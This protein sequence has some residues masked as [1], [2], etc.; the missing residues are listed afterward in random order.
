MASLGGQLSAGLEGLNEMLDAAEV[1]SMQP[2]SANPEDFFVGEIDAT[3]A[4]RPH[5]G[6]SQ[7]SN[8]LLLH[9]HHHHDHL[10]DDQ[11]LA[12]EADA[13]ELLLG[14][15]APATLHGSDS[16][17]SFPAIPEHAELLMLVSHQQQQQQQQQQAGYS[18]SAALQHQ[19]HQQ[20]HQQQPPPTTF[21]P[22]TNITPMGMGMQEYNNNN[23]PLLFTTT[24]LGSPI[25]AVELCCCPGGD[26]LSTSPTV[27]TTSSDAAQFHSFGVPRV[28][29]MPN[30]QLASLGAS[31]S[32]HALAVH[33]S[34]MAAAMGSGSGSSPLSLNSSGTGSGRLQRIPRSRS[35]NDVSALDRYH[36][37]HSGFLTPPHLR[38]GKGGRQPADDPR[39]DPRIDPK[40]AKRILANRL[41][42]AKSKLKQ[43]S[44][45]DGLRQRLEMLRLQQEGLTVEVSS[46]AEACEAKEAEREALRRQLQAVEGAVLMQHPQQQQ[47]ENGLPL[48]TTTPPPPTTTTT[49]TTTVNG[50]NG[51]HSNMG[52]MA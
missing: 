28:A 25:S 22:T 16:W 32:L 41:S 50:F 40:K 3:E 35:A 23:K 37:P 26:G 52:L 42:A 24:N 21:V 6:T 30:L 8:A 38:K 18:T 49:T 10:Q 29:S 44:A 31:G 1:A 34:A 5:L 13:P 12:P 43:K 48:L 14:T 17:T 39:L 46:L 15:S 2:S 9:H 19:H 36:V 45:S 51:M 47:Q 4:S 11:L 33:N 27:S 20:H 7:S